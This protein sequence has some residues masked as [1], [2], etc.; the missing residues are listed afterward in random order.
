MK[1]AGVDFWMTFLNGAAGREHS[2]DHAIY[3]AEV[4]S[5]CEPMLVGIGGLVLFPGTPLLD[6]VEKGEFTPLSEREMLIELRAFA[7]RLS[8]DCSFITHH[9]VSGQNL[10]GP[11]FLER[12]DKILA[13]LDQE[14][15]HG[16]MGRLA[17]IRMNKKTL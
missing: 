11:N 16:D 7:E 9:T 4:F 14:I 5:R 17:A 8:C 15:E 13:A 10:S 1:E 3:S 2:L 12:K 6:D